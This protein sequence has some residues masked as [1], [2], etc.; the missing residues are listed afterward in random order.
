MMKTKAN[1][2]NPAAELLVDF[3]KKISCFVRLF[4]MQLL[5]QFQNTTLWNNFYNVNFIRE[6]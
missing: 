4:S 1:L 5:L 3:G 2:R 6:P